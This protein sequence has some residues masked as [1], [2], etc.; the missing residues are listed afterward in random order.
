MSPF[1]SDF[2]EPVKCTHNFTFIIE[3]PEQR[4]EL[5]ELLITDNTIV[6]LSYDCKSIEREV[7][8]TREIK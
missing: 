4:K 3:T 8:L 5:Q 6:A 7:I 2:T 1:N